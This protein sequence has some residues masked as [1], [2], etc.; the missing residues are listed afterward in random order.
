[1]KN[2]IAKLSS[3]NKGTMLVP[4]V[5][6]LDK[7]TVSV[8]SGHQEF[9]S[10]YAGLGNLHNTTHCSYGLGMQVVAFLPIL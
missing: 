10:V 5:H 2:D 8:A 6:G 1:M 9:H 3:S 4:V 7:T